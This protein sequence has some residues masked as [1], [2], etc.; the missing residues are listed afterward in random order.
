[1]SK[2]ERLQMERLSNLERIETVLD[3]E[4][5]RDVKRF[6]TEDM[7]ITPSELEGDIRGMLEGAGAPGENVDIE[8]RALEDSLEVETEA[9]L[10]E[11][12]F[13]D[14]KSPVWMADVYIG[15]LAGLAVRADP[16]WAKDFF[17]DLH[18]QAVHLEGQWGDEDG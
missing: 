4:V 14:A 12:D 8:F 16:E 1:M 6:S 5:Y 7:E 3:E 17:Y 11:V 9:D 10:T 18:R 15:S 2:Q 13:G